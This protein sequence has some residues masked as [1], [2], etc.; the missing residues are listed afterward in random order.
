LSRLHVEALIRVMNENLR[1]TERCM[2][3]NIRQQVAAA[4]YVRLQ[5]KRLHFERALYDVAVNFALS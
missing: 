3:A 5:R 1:S 4:G 2:E